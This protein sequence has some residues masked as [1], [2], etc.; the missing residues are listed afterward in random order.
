M[1][2][3]RWQE[4]GTTS[5]DHRLGSISNAAKELGVNQST[6]SH[7]LNRLRRILNDPLFIK[8]GRGMVASAKMEA[9]QGPID[10][11][12]IGLAR[13]ANPM[14]FDPTTCRREYLQT[15]VD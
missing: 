5:T 2:G 9:M 12:L 7:N 14:P 15:V 4:S 6:V 10:E 11:V 8:S 13:V 3:H 1:D